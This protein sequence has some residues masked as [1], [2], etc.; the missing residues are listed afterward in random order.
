MC[1]GTRFRKEAVREWVLYWRQ[2]RKRLRADGSGASIDC[3][4]ASANETSYQSVL[5]MHGFAEVPDNEPIPDK[6][7][8]I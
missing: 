5:L 3:R 7:E 2:H 8:C 4:I 1:L 6:W